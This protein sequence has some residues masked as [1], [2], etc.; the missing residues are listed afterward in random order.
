MTEYVGLSDLT[1]RKLLD[2]RGHA[3]VIAEYVGDVVDMVT[4]PVIA[5]ECETCNEV[6]ADFE[7]AAATFSPMAYA[8]TQE[9]Q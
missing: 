5:L 2:H 6:L 4:L 1:A 8:A 9:A 3:V 7:L